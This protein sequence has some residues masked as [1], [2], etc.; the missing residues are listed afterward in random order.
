MGSSVHGIFQA[1]ILEGL[2]FSFSR[3]PSQPMNRTHFS[4]IAG[5]F[6]TTESPGKPIANNLL[7][8]GTWF[9]TDLQKACVFPMD[10]VVGK[11][12]IPGPILLLRK[13]CN[14]RK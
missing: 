5:G 9:H 4:Y 2:A 12:G 14:L 7:L 10:N 3:E 11:T 1:R 8:T 13:V 6:F